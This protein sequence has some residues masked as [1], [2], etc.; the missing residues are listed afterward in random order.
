MFSATGTTFA[1]RGTSELRST[2]LTIHSDQADLSIL[3]DTL[4]QIAAENRISGKS[5]IE[6]QVVLDEIISNAIKYAWPEGGAHE[7][8]VRLTVDGTVIEVEVMDDGQPY[9]PRNAPPPRPAKPG[10]RP[11]PGGVGIQMVKQLVD[12]LD[13]ARV[14]RYNRVRL[15]KR[16]S[17]D[18]QLPS[19]GP[20]DE[21]RT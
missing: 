6:L 15:T 21:Q 16:C 4:D 19:E 7:L 14:D 18:A 1:V 5:L 9:D 12:V 8:L 20:D 13:Y 3:R 11:K 2:E 10:R 17:I